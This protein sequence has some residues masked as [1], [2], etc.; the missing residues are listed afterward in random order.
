VKLEV[1]AAYLLKEPSRRARDI[2]VKV[3]KNK[4]TSG[5]KRIEFDSFMEFV[6]QKNSRIFIV[7][8]ECPFL[9]KT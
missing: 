3:R 8:K 6:V 5:K 1:Y 2:L 7:K 9:A 4:I